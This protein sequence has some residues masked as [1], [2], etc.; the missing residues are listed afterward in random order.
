MCAARA[1]RRDAGMQGTARGWAK[2]RVPG[3][4]ARARGK[5]KR[6][7]A[8][9]LGAGMRFIRGLFH[10]GRVDGYAAETFVAQIEHRRLTGRD[11]ALAVG[12]AHFGC[13]AV[14]RE[15][16]VLQGLT[17]AQAQA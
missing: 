12:K 11:G 10:V 13:I 16:D 17:V 6:R 15:R 2:R 8:G 7:N 9:T 1:K 4:W 14:Q 5:A 3:R